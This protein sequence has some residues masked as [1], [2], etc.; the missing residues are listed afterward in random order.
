MKTL[1]ETKQMLNEIKENY[2]L[3]ERFIE[4]EYQLD[5]D[6]AVVM[7][8]FPYEN[9]PNADFE[10]AFTGNVEVDGVYDFIKGIDQSDL[11]I[12]VCDT[13]DGE[14]KHKDTLENTLKEYADLF[15]PQGSQQVKGNLYQSYQEVQGS[16]YNRA[17]KYGGELH[18]TPSTKLLTEIT[19]EELAEMGYTLK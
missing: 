2:P 10:T 19:H 11:T 6:L 18:E 7:V 1:E 8:A 17:N 16:L 15:Q 3:Y 14:Y 13:T 4:V 12:I 9:E 5:A